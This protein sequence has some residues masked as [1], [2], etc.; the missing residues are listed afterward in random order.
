MNTARYAKLKAFLIHPHNC[1]NKAAARSKPQQWRNR[2]TV[3]II[4]SISLL[5]MKKGMQKKV[6][7]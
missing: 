3:F 7:L 4:L 5:K 2:V 1:F 6:S